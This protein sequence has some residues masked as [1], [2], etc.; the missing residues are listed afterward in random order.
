M[1]W[2]DES[3]RVVQNRLD[4]EIAKAIAHLRSRDAVVAALIDAHGP[5]KL[6]ATRDYFVLMMGTVISQQLSTKAA[7]SIYDRLFDTLGGKSRPRRRPR[8]RPKD[9]LAATDQ[10]LL[11]AGLSRSKVGYVRN[12]AA[13]FTSH[14]MGPRTFARLSDQEV[15]DK[16]TAIKGIG[17]WSAHMFLMFGLNRL[18]VF[19]VGDLGLRNAMV[20]AYGLRKNPSVKRLHRIGDAWRPYRTIGS[21]YLW[22]SYD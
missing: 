2:F 18:D 21:L 19:P 12:V 5:C 14:R 22:M 20:K 4:R 8:L 10:Q 17:E 15:V 1:A 7:R 11:G 6:D 3:N 16:L 9:I 13:A